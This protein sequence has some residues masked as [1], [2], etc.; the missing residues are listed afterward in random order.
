MKITEKIVG[1][2]C[3]FEPVLAGETAHLVKIQTVNSDG[4]VLMCEFKDSN[5]GNSV[6][7]NYMLL[8]IEVPSK[9]GLNLART[10]H[11]YTKGIFE[12]LEQDRPNP[13]YHKLLEYAEQ[14]GAETDVLL[15][16]PI[17]L[18]S[19]WAGMMITENAFKLQDRDKNI[20]AGRSAN[21]RPIIVF[22]LESDVVSEMH[23]EMRRIHRG[24]NGQSL[25]L[26]HSELDEQGNVVFED[27][28]EYTP[29]SNSTEEE[30]EGMPDAPPVAPQRPGNTQQQRR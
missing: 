18:E 27:P 14:Q 20:I 9:G 11:S 5:S 17:K 30:D 8:H 22:G 3:H 7:S 13:L 19:V 12:M 16:K 21:K 25:F 26:V 15:A 4:E 1:S 29:V 23:R 6:V 2:G 28:S 24:V 10:G